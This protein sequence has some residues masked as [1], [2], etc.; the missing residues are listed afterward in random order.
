MQFE[1]KMMYQHPFLTFLFW[2]TVATMASSLALLVFAVVV[3]VVT[4]SIISSHPTK[5][6]SIVPE[7]IFHSVSLKKALL[8]P[9]FWGGK[10][11][12]VVDQPWPV[13]TWVL[14]DISL[15]IPLLT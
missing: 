5:V 11:G 13:Q 9:Y 2:G 10:L 7:M 4:I 1:T 8:N 12:G 14:I 15:M 6:D 3:D